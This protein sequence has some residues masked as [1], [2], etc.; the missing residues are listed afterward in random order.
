LKK[1]VRRAETAIF[2]R[3]DQLRIKKEE[4][5]VLL[6][7]AFVA[8]EAQQAELAQGGVLVQMQ[9]LDHLIANQLTSLE[10]QAWELT[11]SR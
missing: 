5:E 6:P 4:P 1:K 3:A 8:R 9:H 10:S 11:A 7:A 2:A